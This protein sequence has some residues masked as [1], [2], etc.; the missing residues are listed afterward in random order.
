MPAKKPTK[1]IPSIVKPESRLIRFDWA[2]KHLLRNK[3]HFVILEGFLSELLKMDVHIDAVLESESNKESESDKSNQVDLAVS[4]KNGEKVI[5]EIQCVHQWDYLGRMLYG[6]SKMVTEHLKKGEMYGTIPRVYA[7][8]IVFFNLGSGKDYIYK[9]T[10]QFE[11]IHYKDI[12][13][14]GDKE[15]QG[16]K[17]KVKNVS[18]IYPEYYII[19]VDQ[20]N[21]KIKDKID[22]WVYFLKTETVKPGSTAKG[23]KEAKEKLDILKLS[24]EEQRSYDHY[25]LGLGNKKSQHFTYFEAGRLKGEAKGRAEGLVEGKAEGKAEG[26]LEGEAKKNREVVIALNKKRLPVKDI[27]DVTGLTVPEIKMILADR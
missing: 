19:K 5:I 6:T 11:G 13:Q 15:K 21:E 20:F 17:T 27:S 22:Q 8:N 16:Y 25:L 1:K 14:L 4:L 3:I 10:T 26:L 12:L 9:G 2:I 18:E 23:L 7:V 24:P